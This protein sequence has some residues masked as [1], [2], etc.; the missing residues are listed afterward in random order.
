[1]AKDKDR[2]RRREGAGLTELARRLRALVAASETPEDAIDFPV[3][4]AMRAPYEGE[5]SK[6]LET[7]V[8]ERVRERSQMSRRL[9]AAREGL[10]VERYP[11]AQLLETLRTRAGVK[12]EAIAAAVGASAR[13][14][15]ELETGKANPVA[16]PPEV[17]ASL[18]EVFVLPRALLESAIGLDLGARAIRKRLSQPSRRTAGALNKG[19]FERAMR[20]V[21]VA[22]GEEKGSLKKAEVPRVYGQAVTRVLRRRGRT[23][24]L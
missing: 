8:F 11:L 10:E 7:R 20:D 6:D 12:L 1:M 18:M 9:E 3:S 15:Q 13:Q 21:A 17:M 24:L 4:A 23:D 22:L 14:I 16:V 19:D 2:Q 5:L